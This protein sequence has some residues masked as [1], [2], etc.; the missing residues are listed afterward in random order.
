MTVQITAQRGLRHAD[1][2][3]MVGVE[4]LCAEALVW[5]LKRGNSPGGSVPLMM[6]TLSSAM[7]L[8]LSEL[9]EACSDAIM[10]RLKGVSV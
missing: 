10:S 5:N 4:A 2:Y 1:K 6:E 9:Q 3:R 8:R 7:R